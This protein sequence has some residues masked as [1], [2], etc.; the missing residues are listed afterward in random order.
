MGLGENLPK[1]A[2]APVIYFVW[3][4]Q[5]EGT[6]SSALNRAMIDDEIRT[7]RRGLRGIMEEDHFFGPLVPEPDIDPGHHRPGF[8]QVA[9]IGASAP[10]S[11]IHTGALF[12]NTA[13]TEGDVKLQ[14]F[15][16]TSWIDV[17]SMDH[18][19]L[20]SLTATAAHPIYMLR[21]GDTITEEFD[22]GGNSLIA[23]THTLWTRGGFLLYGHR[24]DQHT[25]LTEGN[26]SVVDDT[27]DLAKLSIQQAS[28]STVVPSMTTWTV[29]THENSFFPHVEAVGSVDA[30][31][32]FVVGGGRVI[33]KN[34]SVY[35]YTI[36]V[37]W[38]Y[39][40]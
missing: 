11:N 22:M 21:S 15:N 39:I 31:V 40:G 32:T 17:A 18:A 37:S 28:T 16:G 25:A 35:S 34:Y 2:G 38:E 20:S 33:V 10:T 4:S 8:V 6:P 3:D 30:D 24:G 12:I 36:R 1:D 13:S 9:D 14:L 23:D 26:W 29:I 5:Y 27:L 7:M 19:L